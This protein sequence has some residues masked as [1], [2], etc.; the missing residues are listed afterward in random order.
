MKK[1]EM[2]KNIIRMYSNNHMAVKRSESLVVLRNHQI[3]IN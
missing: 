2:I 1:A 3:H